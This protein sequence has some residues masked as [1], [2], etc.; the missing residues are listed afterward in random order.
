MNTTSEHP[1]A[2]SG[3]TRIRP[4]E[5]GDAAM[6][7]E[8][9]ARIFVETYAPDNRREDVDAFVAQAFGPDLQAREIADPAT[10]YLIAEVDG[11]PAGYVLLRPDP[12]PECI[13][14]G[15][16][17]SIARFY[18]DHAWHG[19]GIAHALMDAALA[20]AAARGASAVW[21]TVWER[22]DRALA[23]YRKRGFTIVGE[24]PFTM[25][26]DV[27]NDHVMLRELAW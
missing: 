2:Q 1:I 27:Q 17:L 9:A 22:N 24:M 11:A 16:T 4:A 23:F 15:R 25:G 7:A 10:C 8:L 19:R 5:P 14:A 18:V 21:L 3:S 12:A 26:A 13:P 6:L 20:E